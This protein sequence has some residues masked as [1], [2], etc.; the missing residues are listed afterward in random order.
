MTR[1]LLVAI[2]LVPILWV[3]PQRGVTAAFYANPQWS[4]E[5]ALV[6]VERKIN[7]DFMTADATSFPQQ[8]FSIEWSGW[9][10]LDDDGQYTFFTTSDD[11]STIEIDGRLVV[12][13]GGVHRAMLRTATIAM[14]RGL[15]QIRVRF[16]QATDLYEFRAA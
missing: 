11:G 2:V 10:R 9:L 6:R 7:L 3:W 15:H 4:N 8:E 12:D 16:M 13:N 14:T 1:L 5:P